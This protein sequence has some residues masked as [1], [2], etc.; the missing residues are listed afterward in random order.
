M[1]DFL[2]TWKETGWPHENILRMIEQVDEQGYADEPWRIFAHKQAKAGDRVWVLKQGRSPKGIFGVGEI[3]GPPALGEAGNGKTQWMAPVRFSTFVDPKQRLLLS[4]EIANKI[5]RPAQMNAPASGYPLDEEQAISLEAALA[6][7]PIVELGGS[8]D[9]TKS[10]LRLIVGDY[11]SMLD[12][13]L[14]GRTYSKTDHRN[15]L[16]NVL[17]RSEGSIERKH[18]NISAVLHQL[19]LPWVRGYKPLANFQDALVAAVEERLDQ[20]VAKL[21]QAPTPIP[22]VEANTEKVFVKPPAKSTRETI[23]KPIQKIVRKFDPALRDEANRQ[24]GRAGEEFV[25][26]LEQERLA[27]LGKA[28]LVAGITW[29]SRDIGDGLGYDIESFSEEEA[30]IYIEVKTTRGSIDTSFFISENERRVA[31]EKGAAFRLYRVFDFGLKPRI[32]SLRGKHA[33]RHA[34]GFASSA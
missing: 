5:L 23:R 30:R 18:H 11:F 31:A 25:W 29:V 26:R 21:D 28:H 14:N 4:E 8:G 32:Y 17:R 33:V 10:E 22:E 1:T 20:D 19:G 2:L 7:E 15:D 12:D 13:E 24:L 9:W 3:V 6:S 34:A 16:G 27:A